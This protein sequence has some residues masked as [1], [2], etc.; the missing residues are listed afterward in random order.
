[1]DATVMDKNKVVPISAGVRRSKR[2]FIALRVSKG[3][4]GIEIQWQSVTDPRSQPGEADEAVGSNAT[5]RYTDLQESEGKYWIGRDNCVGVLG[6]GTA[7]R[8]DAVLLFSNLEE[9]RTLTG[10]WHM[11][12]FVNV[13]NKLPGK[14]KVSRFENR[15]IALERLWRAIKSIEEQS[16]ASGEKGQEKQPVRQSKTECVMNLLKAPGGA[17]LAALMQATGWQ[18]HSVRGFLSR[19]LSKQSGL[20]LASFRRDGERVYA[21]QAA[22]VQDEVQ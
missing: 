14:R 20:Q 21:L 3:P 15:A 8:Q 11:R 22:Q 12:Q 5:T 17:T 4:L 18:A 16:P 9:L 13:W 10:E 19:K 1:M 2:K 6:A 7:K